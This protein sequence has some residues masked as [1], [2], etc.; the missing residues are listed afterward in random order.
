MCSD[1]PFKRAALPNNKPTKISL[2][3]ICGLYNILAPS[4]RNYY[5]LQ[6]YFAQ[7]FKN[8]AYL[9]NINYIKG[10]LDRADYNKKNCEDISIKNIAKKETD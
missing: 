1:W 5:G 10:K 3:V 9:N 4:P 8:N 7:K 6:L 2:I